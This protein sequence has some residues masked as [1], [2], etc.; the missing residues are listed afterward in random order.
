MEPAT[1]QDRSERL[2]AGRCNGYVWFASQ[3]ER[4]EAW[5]SRPD[6]SILPIPPMET[7][8]R[9]SS[10]YSLISDKTELDLGQGMW[11]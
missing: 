11:P 10:M 2:R 5:I 3:P 7:Q 6:A 8:V 4:R 9:T 1:S